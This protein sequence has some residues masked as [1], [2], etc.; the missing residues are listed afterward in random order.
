MQYEKQFERERCAIEDYK[1]NPACPKT[2]QKGR[3]FRVRVPKHKKVNEFYDFCKRRA[4]LLSSVP[5]KE[6][7]ISFEKVSVCMLTKDTIYSVE[8]QVG[9]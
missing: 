7:S 4:S 5:A 1:A 8:Y 2:G 6:I 3:R 9:A